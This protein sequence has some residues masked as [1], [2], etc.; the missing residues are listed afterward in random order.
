MT[1]E[2]VI[3]SIRKNPEYKELVKLAYFEEDLKLNVERF[4]QSEEYSETQRILRN[5]FKE[6]INLKLADIG[7]GNGIASLAFA[8][9]GFHVT[10]VEPDPSCTIGAGAIK[11]LKEFYNLEN[12]N[13]I[14][15]KGES[16]S[17]NASSFDIVYIRQAMHHA[18]DINKFVKEAARLLNTNGILLTVR[19]HLIYNNSDKEWFLR[20]HPLHKFYGG[21]NAYTIDEYRNAILNSGLKIVDELRHYDSVINFYPESASDIESKKKKQSDFIEFHFNK[22]VPYGIRN[23]PFLK[24]WYYKRALKKLSPVLD[25]SKIPGRHISFIAVKS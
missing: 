9:D 22:K 15:E 6:K 4:I 23:F 19:D 17:L 13:V 5:Y 11:F 2:E 8:L 1:W 24:K 20:S 18:N 14:E 3:I 21:E 7:A 25:E 16:L 12:L 10:A